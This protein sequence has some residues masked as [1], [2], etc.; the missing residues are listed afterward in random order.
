MFHKVDKEKILGLANELLELQRYFYSQYNVDDIFSNSKIFEILIADSLGHILIPGHSG[1]RD[2]RDQQGGEIEYKHFKETSSNHSWTFN[3]F[4][5]TTIEKLN[6]TKYVLFTHINDTDGFYNFDWYY[7]VEGAVMAKYLKE[8]TTS[9][10]NTRK[11]INVSARQLE[12][13][14]GIQKTT[15]K[16][17]TNGTYTK[18]L[19][20]IYSTIKAMEAESNVKNILTS[21]KIWELLTSVHLNHNVNSEQGGRVGAHDAF[22]EDGNQFEYKISKATNWNF[23]DIS[24]NVLTKYEELKYFIL[25]LKDVDTVSIKKIYVVN[26]NLLTRIREKLEEKKLKKG[27]DLRRLQISITL[28]DI[29]PFIVQEI[30]GS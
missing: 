9:I 23:Q 3:D 16:K 1:S 26:T 30:A 11:M 4:S 27:K 15:V 12:S 28:K 19:D 13:R 29:K 24:E 10:Q 6:D 22:D 2:A 8:A 21:N 18:D 5:D 7:Q 17:I 14:L 25:A 20:R